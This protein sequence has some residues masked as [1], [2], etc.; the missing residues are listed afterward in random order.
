M[1]KD[2]DTGFNLKSL[3]FKPLD[4]SEKLDRSLGLYGLIAISL[5][6]TLGSTLFVIPALG[7]DILAESG[8]T[9]AGLWLAF[10]IAGLIVLPSALSKAE[11]GTAMPSS[12]GSY[13][14][15]R[16]TY[17]AW[18]GMIS[19]L[20]LW[21]SFGLKS[22]FA[23]I[24]FSAYIYAVQGSLGF[25]LTENIS[26]IIAIFLLSIIVFINIMGVHSSQ[27]H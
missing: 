16:Q 20:G 5:S 23:L 3:I 11:L 9:G 7:A 19:G 18:M 12:G 13:V 10:I 1:V 27:N 25:E 8:G 2:H 4:I 17:G 26:K 14:Y 6:A 24:G 21:A 15:I 22:A